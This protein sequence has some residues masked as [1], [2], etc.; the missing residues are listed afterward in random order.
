MINSVVCALEKL[1][2]LL[3]WVDYKRTA[4]LATLLLILTGLASGWLVRVLVSLFCVHRF[5]KGLFFYREKHY[6]RNRMFAVYGLR[7]IMHKYFPAVIG[8]S[9]NHIHLPLA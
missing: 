1:G 9:K 6:V 5:Y 8:D 3:S 7:Y 4:F 2:N